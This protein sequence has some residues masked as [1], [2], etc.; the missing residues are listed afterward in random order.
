MPR[1]RLQRRHDKINGC[2]CS[3]CGKLISVF[4]VKTCPH[5]DVDICSACW[6][7]NHQQHTAKD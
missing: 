5:C 2:S 4:E 7:A 6:F 1:Y 3:E